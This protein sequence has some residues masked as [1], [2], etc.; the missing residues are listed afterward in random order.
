MKV[1]DRAKGV[2][3]ICGGRECGNEALEDH[4]IISRGRWLTRWT[5]WNHILI[6]R[7][8]HN[9]AYEVRQWVERNWRTAWRLIRRAEMRIAAGR[10]H[11]R[12]MNPVRI[13]ER[14]KAA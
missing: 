1:F 7:K 9:K 2:C 4:H 13:R 14:I 11:E 10:Y 6:G 3:E 12:G 5:L 8:H